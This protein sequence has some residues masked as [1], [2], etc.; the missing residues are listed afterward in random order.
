MKGTDG[1][2]RRFVWPERAVAIETGGSRSGVVVE[3]PV[4]DGAAAESCITDGTRRETTDDKAAGG[5]V[6]SSGFCWL[7]ESPGE[8]NI[9][10]TL[11]V[12]LC[13]SW[14][15]VIGRGPRGIRDL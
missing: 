3:Y 7:T 1:A 9:P 11:K 6:E 5:K 2:E 4:R 10:W 14:L 13:G 15:G 8:A 12:D